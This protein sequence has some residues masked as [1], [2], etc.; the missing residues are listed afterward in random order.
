MRHH[1]I[2]GVLGR[3]FQLAQLLADIGEARG[4]GQVLPV[5]GEA[6]R[7]LVE[8]CLR[9]GKPCASRTQALAG[10]LPAGFG[11]T[12]EAQAILAADVVEGAFELRRYQLTRLA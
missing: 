12:C 11:F 6:I 10:I 2:G 7:H 8:P 4:A 5:A 1:L 9:L 3:G